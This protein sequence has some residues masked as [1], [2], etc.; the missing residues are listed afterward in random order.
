MMSFITS[1]DGFNP[2]NL[3]DQLRNETVPLRGVVR[4]LKSTLDVDQ[5]VA[6]AMKLK[7]EATTQGV[8]RYALL[9]SIK[10]NSK[11]TAAE[12][13]FSTIDKQR[14]L[15][16]RSIQNQR[17]LIYLNNLVDVILLSFAHPKS[18]GK[19]FLV[20]NSENEL[21]PAL[22]SRVAIALWRRSLLLVAPVSLLKLVSTL[23]GKKL[24]V[25]SSLRPLS[26]DV[27]SIRE[28]LGWNQLYTMQARL[29]A[30]AEWL[31]I[32]KVSVW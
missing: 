1:P 19:S 31:R 24:A 17:S 10:V 7:R 6:R 5:N 2:S 11:M 12:Q 23:L 27:T 4:S 21:L 22:I 14:P 26:I 9:N 13:P 16:I 3:C 20:S 30:T 32:T 18:A 29:T 8:S 28:D 15:P 25:E